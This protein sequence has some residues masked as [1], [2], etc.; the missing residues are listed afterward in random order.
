[1][2]KDMQKVVECLRACATGSFKACKA[3]SYRKDCNQLITDALELLEK[4]C[5]LTKEVHPMSNNPEENKRIVREGLERRKAERREAQEEARLEQFE[6]DMIRA[7]N[8]NR[9]NTKIEREAVAADRSS[10]TQSKARIA[11][12]KDA[13]FRKMERETG[14]VHAVAIYAVAV[15]FLFWLTTW[16][17]LPMYAA[18]TCAI[19]FFPFLPIYV[20]RLY[21][22]IE[23]SWEAYR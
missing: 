22:P 23:E 13:K 10:K 18:I 14:T 4:G 3:C 5:D 12:R 17:H 2:E 16:T 15:A 6:R 19:S 20:S 9:A 1:M 11:S 8:E 7:C 21:E